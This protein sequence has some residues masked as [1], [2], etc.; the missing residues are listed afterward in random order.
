MWNKGATRYVETI[1]GASQGRN[2]W[3]GVWIIARI[4]LLDRRFMGH[5]DL[6]IHRLY[7]VLYGKK[8]GSRRAAVKSGRPLAMV[9]GKMEIIPVIPVKGGLPARWVGLVFF[10]GFFV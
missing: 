4:T 6:C 5:A 8:A 2:R 1:I 3:N 7:R 9:D 10:M